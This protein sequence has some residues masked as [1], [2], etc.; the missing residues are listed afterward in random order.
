[1]CGFRCPQGP[2]TSPP[3]YTKRQLHLPRTLTLFCNCWPRTI[4][5]S[6]EQ[7]AHCSDT[8]PMLSLLPFIYL[9]ESL[10]D[11]C[12]AQGPSHQSQWCPE[13][14]QSPKR[15]YGY[16]LHGQAVTEGYQSKP[17]LQPWSGILCGWLACICWSGCTPYNPTVPW[18]WGPAP[19]F[20]A[21]TPL[22]ACPTG[23]SLSLALSFICGSAR[24]RHNK[25]RSPSAG[26]IDLCRTRVRAL[27]PKCECDKVKLFPLQLT[28]PN[29]QSLPWKPTQSSLQ[30]LGAGG[31]KPAPPPPV[32]HN[33]SLDIR[34][35]G[36]SRP[37][38]Q[39]A[40]GNVLYRGWGEKYLNSD[41]EYIKKKKINHSERKQQANF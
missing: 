21:Q 38:F 3:K 11:F 35:L 34:L 13:A 23:C 8:S 37:A 27:F 15:T 39:R 26:K 40:W 25:K 10:L 6:R 9:T 28:S 32:N 2:R 12:F 24:R 31:R 5:S 4:L 22:P 29:Q 30:H 41:W 1:M 19:S 16:A 7:T 18:T 36:L 33:S 14:Q 20:S 17:R